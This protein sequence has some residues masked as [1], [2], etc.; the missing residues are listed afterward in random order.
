MK[1]QQWDDERDGPLTE[2]SVRRRHQPANAFRVSRLSY[3]PGARF[4][5]AARAGTTFVLDGSCRIAGRDWSV[6]L[7]KGQYADLPEGKFDFETVEGVTIVS[8]W[9]LP[10]QFRG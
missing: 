1:P 8:V 4:V 5:G 2:E 3:P 6:E 10:P 9:L 7:C